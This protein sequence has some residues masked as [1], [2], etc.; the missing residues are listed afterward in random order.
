MEFATASGH[1]IRVGIQTP[2]LVQ[3][4]GGHARWEEQAGVAELKRVVVAA[5]DLGYHHLTCSEH[6]A[7]PDVESARRGQTYWDPVSTLAWVAAITHDIRLATNVV[8]VGYHHPLEV[9]K[10]YGTLDRLSAGRLILGVGVGTLREEFELLDAPFEDRGARADDALAAIRAGW[11][12]ARVEY[13]G[14]FYQYGPLIIEPH[15]PRSDL[16]VW[17]GGRSVR[18]LRRAVELGHGWTP[19]ALSLPRIAAM[20]GELDLPEGFDVVLPPG[21]PLDPAADPDGTRRQLDDL[22]GAGATAIHAAFVHHSLDHYLEQL[23]ALARV[24]ES[25]G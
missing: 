22:G 18:S 25:T 3:T 10:Q 20:L 8:V 5:D 15:A 21:R 9:L 11:G 6:F 19:F 16:P 24:A 12:Q 2:I 13:R 4:P 1:R 14:A 23:E 17:V 7:L